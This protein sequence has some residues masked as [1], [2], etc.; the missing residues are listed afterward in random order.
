MFEIFLSH[1]RVCCSPV[2]GGGYTVETLEGMAKAGY[3]FKWQGRK[4]KLG[5]VEQEALT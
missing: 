5:K 3:T 1:R 2:E 4:W